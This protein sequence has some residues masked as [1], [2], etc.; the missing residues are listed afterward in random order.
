MSD[1]AL[2]TIMLIEDE[3]ADSLIIRRAFEKAGVEN[4]IQTMTNGDA[5]LAYLEGIGEYQ[6]R[7]KYPLPIFILLDL[8][9]P[10]MMGLQLLKWIRTKKDL[11]LIPIVVL[12]NSAE[13]SNVKSAYEAGANSYLLKP[14]D[15]GEVDR[16]I[17]V[18]QN[19]WLEHNVSPPLVL[20]AKTN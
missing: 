12:T 3:A 5:A 20:R 17:H 19:Y 4:P 16:V 18:I 11:R 13:D 15:R 8:K 14:A 9:L 2:G 6:N 10:G 7:T 1:P